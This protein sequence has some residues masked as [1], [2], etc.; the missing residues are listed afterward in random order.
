MPREFADAAQMVA[1]FRPEVPVYC[2]RPALFRRAAERFLEGFPGRVLYAVKAN[3]QP[4][5]LDLLYDAGIRHFDTASL[6]EIALV[7]GRFPEATCYF[8][9]PVKGEAA[10]HEAYHAHGVRHFVV[11]H[12]DE[13]DKMLRVL[14]GAAPDLA[15]LVRLAT[16][17]QGALFD[18]SGKFGAGPEPAAALLRAA[19]EAGCQAGLCFHVGSQCTEPAAYRRALELSGEVAARAA[20]ELRWLDVGGGFPSAYETPV[21]PL[22]RF[23]EAIDQGLRHFGPPDDCVVMCEPGR[24]LVA[25]AVSVVAQVQHRR[26]HA[27]YLNDGIYGSLSGTKIGT[28]YPVRLLR[29]SGSASSEATEFTIYGPTCDGLDELGYPFV[30]PRDTRAGDWIE[31]GMLGAYAFSVR[32]DFNGF[33][34]ERAV[35][36]ADDGPPALAASCGAGG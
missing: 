26:D 13:L 32:T 36:V 15:V 23:L 11:D 24:A 22:A 20:V 6:G 21:P 8:M 9:H 30:L 10:I 17:G 7:S 29:P 18:L 34:P 2:L 16:P 33:R 31:V 3:P 1:E 12:A 35:W 19:A 4:E 27:L 5:V 14:G 28:I 25:D